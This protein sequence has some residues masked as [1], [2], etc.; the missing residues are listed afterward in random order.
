MYESNELPSIQLQIQSRYETHREIRNSQ[1]KSRL[2]A[3]EF[4]GWIVDSILQKLIYQAKHPGY[5]DP[6]HCLVFWARPPHHIRHIVGLIQEKLR[7][8]MPGLWLSVSVFSALNFLDLWFMPLECLHMTALEVAHSMTE[9]Q[10]EELLGVLKSKV[11]DITDYTFNHRA[12]L[13]K[14]LLSYDNQAIALSFLPA[15]NEN[16][17]STLA[18]EENAYTYHHLRRDLYDLCESNGIAVGS[19]YVVPSAHLTIARYVTERRTDEDEKDQFSGSEGMTKWVNHL[20]Q[21]N[22]WLKEEFW[23]NSSSGNEAEVDWVVG[24][25]R[26]LD[27]RA[28][29]LWYGGG[30]S[31][32][33]GKGFTVT[34]PRP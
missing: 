15:S 5:V 26:G 19:R 24:E 8:L 10:I 1:Q 29:T 25:E 14:P 4:P 12:R 34:R 28:G 6:R 22:T 16:V 7:N 20:E 17:S 30:R 21:I 2:I 3:P 11:L 31:V 27:C 13:F 33:V 32:H 23:L 9:S 18:G